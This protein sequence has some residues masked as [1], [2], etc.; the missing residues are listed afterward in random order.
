MSVKSRC[1]SMKWLIPNILFFALSL[2]VFLYAFVWYC[3]FILHCLRAPFLFD[4]VPVLLC[5]SPYIYYSSVTT[6]FSFLYF[7]CFWNQRYRLLFSV[8]KLIPFQIEFWQAFRFRIKFIESTYQKSQTKI[9][10]KCS[11]KVNIES[12]IL[13]LVENW[14]Q[15]LELRGLG[16][17]PVPLGYCHDPWETWNN[18][19]RGDEQKIRSIST[20]SF[21]AFFHLTLQILLC[22]C[23]Q[24]LT[25]ARTFSLGLQ[26]WSWNCWHYSVLILGSSWSR[27]YWEHG[28][29]FNGDADVQ[30]VGWK[31]S[32]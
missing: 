23:L 26:S 24:H 21:T 6:V 15:F 14:V 4:I 17:W 29:G 30:K 11:V 5:T 10:C 12:C 32:F 20:T 19:E 2:L 28:L 25:F 1:W 18:G 9:V 27:W 7:S 13:Y 3:Y 22:D 31:S 8:S 16:N